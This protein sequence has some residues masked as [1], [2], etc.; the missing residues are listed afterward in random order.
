MSE[1]R[2]NH[3]QLYGA[4]GLTPSTGFEN[5]WNGLRELLPLPGSV[6]KPAQRAL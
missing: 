3:L 6:L 1:V 4:L 5:Y 2:E